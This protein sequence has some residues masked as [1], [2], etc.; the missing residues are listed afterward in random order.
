MREQ[1]QEWHDIPGYNG[2]YQINKD[3]D[4]RSTY[5]GRTRILT[6]RP[7]KTK[8][9]A[10]TVQLTKGPDFPCRHVKVLQL[11]VITFLGGNRPGLRPYHKDGNNLNNA[12]YNIGFA[13]Q[14]EIGKRFGGRYNRKP[15]AKVTRTGEVIEV[16][17]SVREAGRKNF[18]D[19]GQ[20]S[21]RCV[22]K[23]ADE[24]DVNGC[25]FRYVDDVVRDGKEW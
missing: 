25:S 7:N 11:M 6:C 10:V 20:I 18:I 21:D 1:D 22:G 9:R 15:V 3:G 23:V 2:R 12:L 4:V 16:Y 17:K 19:Y 14:S 13:T 24:Y 5:M 8:Y